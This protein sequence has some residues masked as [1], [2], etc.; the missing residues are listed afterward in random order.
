MKTTKFLAI[1]A[2]AVVLVAASCSS[3]GSEDSGSADNITTTSQAVAASATTVPPA[4]TSST[5][6]ETPEEISVVVPFTAANGFGT[7][8][9]SGDGSP[10]AAW[11]ANQPGEVSLDLVDADA[12]DTASVVEELISF[13][14]FQDENS[15]DVP[16]SIFASSGG[17]ISDSVGTRYVVEAQPLPP[18]PG[19]ETTTAT[20]VAASTT[21]T[22]VT[23]APSSTT[24]TS[25][26]QPGNPEPSV[27]PTTTSTTT[28]APATTTTSTTAVE[29]P[30]VLQVQVLNGSGVT[31]AA[32]RLTD[33][34]S[35]A[36]YVVL[37]AGNA[38]ERYA[39]SAVY[40]QEGWQA[41]A[42]EILQIAEIEEIGQVTAMP[43]QFASDEAAVVVL[44][45]TDTAP[46]VVAEQAELRPK[47]DFSVKL[48][49]GD[50]VP[51]DRFVPGLANIQMYTKQNEDDPEVFGQLVRFSDWL[52]GISHHANDE[53]IFGIYPE[54]RQTREGYLS[55][56]QAIRRLSAVVRFHASECVRRAGWVFVYG[57]V[58]AYQG[59][60]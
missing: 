17:D 20:T 36:G 14:F 26:V 47:P 39:S 9:I 41:K 56:M 38:P 3:S 58:G 35:Q 15:G 49:L 2:L 25:S 4:T 32:G 52:R 28:A 40:Y 57:F 45:G 34:L 37:P 23:S 55:L 8:E 42:E 19:P 1:A 51:R 18:A 7:V 46:A 48:P 10:V 54:H 31:G 50:D 6:P 5:L 59:V 53:Y 60:G 24:T 30:V 12:T 11:F 44:L 43:Q 33:K 27:S 22:A 29:S 16:P 13:W 21:T